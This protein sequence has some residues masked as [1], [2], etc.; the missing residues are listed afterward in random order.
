MGPPPLPP[1]REGPR[2]PTPRRGIGVGPLLEPLALA[3]APGRPVRLAGLDDPGAL[4]PRRSVAAPVRCA[5][6][7]FRQSSPAP[8]PR[9]PGGPGPLAG[10]LLGLLRSVLSGRLSQTPRLR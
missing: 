1:P 2:A 4:W 7:A 3:R 5:A 9:L 6:G 10:W 8:L